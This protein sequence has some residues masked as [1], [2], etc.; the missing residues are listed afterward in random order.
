MHE[1]ILKH[2]YTIKAFE[3][4]GKRPVELSHPKNMGAHPLSYL[5]L[6]FDP[7]YFLYNNRMSPESL[8]NITPDEQYWATRRNVIFRNTGEFPVEI[9][10]PDAEK[11]ANYIFTREIK[12]FKPGRC[13]YQFACYH[14]GGMITDGVMLHLS[15]EKLWMAQADGELIK[16]YLAFANNFNVS[17]KDPNVWVTQIQGPKSMEVLADV[18]DGDFP[19]PWKYFDISRVIIAG[20]EVII[21]R[22]GFTNEL[23][24]EIYLRPENNCEVIGEH[25][26]QI[27]KKYGM[28]LVATPGFRARRIE[29]GL[30]SANND[31]NKNTTP[32]EVGLGRFVDMDKE[33]FVG[34]AALENAEKDSKIWGFKVRSGIA[35]RGRTISSKGNVIGT[36]SSSTWSPYLECGVGIVRVD[37][38]DIGPGNDVDIKGIDGKPYSAQICTLPMYDEKGLI[39]RGINKDIPNTSKAWK[40]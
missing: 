23:G 27:G 39:V 34:K 24:W 13:S 8:N 26:M 5:E 6:P 1:N 9:S 2:R 33:D 31:F 32:Y 18:I 16:W 38:N 14:D 40:G 17:I 28:M 11:F 22:T 35:L 10:G 29:A 30:L 20:E 3:N 36:V 19:S 7:E 21:T 15:R 37:S 12:N 25:I 4:K